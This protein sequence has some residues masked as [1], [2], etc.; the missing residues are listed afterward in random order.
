MFISCNFDRLIG[1]MD[2]SRSL[3]VALDVGTNNTDL[4]NDPLYVVCSSLF[5]RVLFSLNIYSKGWPEKRITGEAYDNFIE[6]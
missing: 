1:G 6:K 2:P 3:C 5:S 4:L